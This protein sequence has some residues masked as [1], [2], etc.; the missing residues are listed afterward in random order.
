MDTNEI[1]R[2]RINTI[3]RGSVCEVDLSATP[4]CVRVCLGDPD[5]LANPG[6]KTN[7][8]PFVPPRAGTVRIWNPPS[9]GEQVVLL[10]PMGD[11]AQGIACGGLFSEAF[12]PPS[13]NPDVHAVQYPDEAVVQYDHKAH[14]LSAILPKGATVEVVAPGQVTV[15]TNSAVVR[16]DAIRL[17]GDVTVTKSMKVKGRL[18]IESGL[19]GKGSLD[20]DG[21]ATFSDDVTAAGISVARH[22]HLAQGPTSPTSK[23]LPAGG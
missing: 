13:R 14:K 8:V 7:W 20:I 4:P 21:G 12:A 3:R 15:Q 19:R 6:L 17:D 5:N 22:P 16:A 23:P 2:L 9:V 18:D 11:L 10:C 1:R